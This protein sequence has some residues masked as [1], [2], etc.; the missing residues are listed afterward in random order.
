MF[1]YISTLQSHVTLKGRY[2]AVRGGK[3]IELFAKFF[4]EEYFLFSQ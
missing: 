1:I 3:D 4:D 2:G